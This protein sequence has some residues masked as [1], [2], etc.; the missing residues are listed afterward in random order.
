MS[1]L[2]F[3][4]EAVDGNLFVAVERNEQELPRDNLVLEANSMCCSGKLTYPLTSPSAA[5]CKQLCWQP[6]EGQG[7]GSRTSGLTQNL[8][9]GLNTQPELAELLQKNLYFEA[10]TSTAP[11]DQVLG[12]TLGKW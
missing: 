3:K 5:G 9:P 4:G 7:S 10:E 6:T 12:Y 1:R 11:S 8:V 2:V